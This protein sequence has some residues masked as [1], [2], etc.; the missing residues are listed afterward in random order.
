MKAAHGEPKLWGHQPDLGLL[1]EQLEAAEQKQPRASVH[2]RRA[3]FAVNRFAMHPANIMVI[4]TLWRM[5]S[6]FHGGECWF[7][8]SWDSNT[9]EV[10]CCL[11]SWLFFRAKKEK[12]MA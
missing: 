7:A 5:M 2:A 3:S 11:I 12:E 4:A 10:A 6:G 1:L 9:A 8:H